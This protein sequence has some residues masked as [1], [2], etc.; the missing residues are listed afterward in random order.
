KAKASPRHK[1]VWL[2]IGLAAFGFGNIMLMS[3]P[4]Y[5]G[6]DSFNG[7]WFKALA[8]WLSLAMALPVVTYSAADFW[9]AAWLGLRQRA[10]TLEVPIA[11]GLAAIYLSSIIAVATHRGPGY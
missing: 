6:L 7:P 2:Q 11:F 1:K 10:L 4:F 3:L 9:R 8:G 5:F